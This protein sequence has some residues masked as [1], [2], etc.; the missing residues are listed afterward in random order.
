MSRAST[1]SAV[2]RSLIEP[3]S[4]RASFA[5]SSASAIGSPWK[6]PPLMTRPPPVAIVSGVGDAAAGEDERVVGRR[7]ELD[8]EDPAQVVERVAHGAV[9][10]RHA[11]QRVRVLD[12]VR[13]SRD[14]PLEPAV[15]QQVAQLGGDGDL[16]RVRPG[17]LVGR[18]ERDVRARAAPRRDMRGGDA[19]GPDQ[20]VGVGQEQRPDARPSSACR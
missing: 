14:G 9:D 3:S 17:E 1:S 20:P 6:L 5:K 8:V 10:L 4:A 13:S 19:R 7:V 12:L 15:A 16:A 2:R 11:A 18:G